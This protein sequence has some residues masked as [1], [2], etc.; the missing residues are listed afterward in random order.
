MFTKIRDFARLYNLLELNQYNYVYV[1]IG[2]KYNSD[3]VSFNGM[4]Y[5][6]NA[7]YQ[8]QPLFIKSE[9]TLKTLCIMIDKLGKKDNTEEYIHNILY[10]NVDFILI[11]NYF[12]KQSIVWFLDL[13]IAKLNEAEF[14]KKNVMIANYIRYLNTP[15]NAEIKIENMIPRTIHKML[16]D[17]NY[18]N[19]FYQWF[20]YRKRLYNYIYNYNILKLL[21]NATAHIHEAEEII[22]KMDNSALLSTTVIQNRQINMLLQNIY[23]IKEFNYYN[24]NM[25]ISKYDM[26]IES[27]QLLSI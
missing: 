4:L 24:S 11:D 21:P 2:S 17:T 20:G 7:C 12:D 18:S 19:C 22:K 9:N 27:D 6:T 8:M 14:P 5:E 13:L 16:I 26:G 3:T 15:N 10:E 23:S 25:A 1:S